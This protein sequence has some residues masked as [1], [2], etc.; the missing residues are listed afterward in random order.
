MREGKGAAFPERNGNQNSL[1][2]AA[3]KPVRARPLGLNHLTYSKWIET[4]PVKNENTLNT[5]T[6]V[7]V[8]PIREEQDNEDGKS[9]SSIANE[10]PKINF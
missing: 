7:S 1:K 4:S 9:C 6:D 3:P 8:D 2:I 10:I 5:E